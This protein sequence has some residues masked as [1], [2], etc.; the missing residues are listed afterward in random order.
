MR[1]KGRSS[2]RGRKVTDQRP[3]QTK[4][5]S[6]TEIQGS[7]I[8]ANLLQNEA[9]RQIRLSRTARERAVCDRG[10][11]SRARR[12]QHFSET[13]ALAA[14]SRCARGIFARVH[15]LRFSVLAHLHHSVVTAHRYPAH[16]WS[17][18]RR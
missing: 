13:V 8:C 9:D 14:E 17:S 4:R 5:G 12:R 16:V 10:A 18:L 11:E 7:E 6:G 2:S 15:R 3:T 1:S